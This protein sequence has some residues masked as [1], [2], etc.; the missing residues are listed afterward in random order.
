VPS[1]RPR[2]NRGKSK[3]RN[4]KRAYSTVVRVSSANKACLD[5]RIDSDRWSFFYSFFFFIIIYNLFIFVIIFI[6]YFHLL[7][8]L[9]TYYLLLITYYLLLITYYL[10]FIFILFSSDNGGEKKK[11]K[12]RA[13]GKNR[14]SGRGM[15]YLPRRL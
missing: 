11:K 7:F 5:P 15:P 4:K 14:S 1:N 2:G 8:S 3:I 12:K 9:I 6:C 13:S 10:L